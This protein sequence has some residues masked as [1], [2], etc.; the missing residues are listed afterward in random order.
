MFKSWRVTTLLLL[1]AVTAADATA[2]QRFGRRGRGGSMYWNDGDD[3]TIYNVPYDGR[4][5]FVR[6]S[7]TPGAG[8]DAW[9]GRR[10]RGQLWWDHDWPTAERNLMQLVRELTSIY[11]YLD[12]SQILGA[13]DPE[14]HKYP[15]AYVSEPGYWTVNEAEA[16]GLRNYLLK[17]GFLIFDDFSGPYEFL[18]LQQCMAQVLPNVRIVPLDVSHPVFHSFFSLDTLN[19]THPYEGVESEFWGIH[20]DND[21]EKRLM[22]IINYNNDIGE[23][24]EFSATGWFPV[25]LTNDAYKLGINYIVYAMTH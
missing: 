9:W 6:L 19:F 1:L 10:G 5:T 13:D 25:P 8:G 11:P 17:G 21:P 14:L 16:E 4:F 7:F 3:Y 24:W 22:A 2:G 15:V 18:N 23:L 20:E 12:G